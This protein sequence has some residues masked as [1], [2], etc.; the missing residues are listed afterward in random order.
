MTLQFKAEQAAKGAKKLTRPGMLRML[1][2][3]WVIDFLDVGVCMQKLAHGQGVFTLA[4]HAQSQGFCAYG[5]TMS[6]LWP[7][8]SA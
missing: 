6:G 7:Q 5:N 1:S 3:A 2:K 8:A 4:L